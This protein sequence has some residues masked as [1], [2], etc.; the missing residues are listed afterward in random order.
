MDYLSR[1]K[2]SY[3]VEDIFFSTG[4][5]GTECPERNELVYD[6]AKLLRRNGLRNQVRESLFGNNCRIDRVYDF[7]GAIIDYPADNQFIK[8]LLEQNI[9]KYVYF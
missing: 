8:N 6:A 7:S 1:E 3:V 5:R 2:E 9:G 4:F